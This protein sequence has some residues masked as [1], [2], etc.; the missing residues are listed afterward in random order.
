MFL[1]EG[2]GENGEHSISFELICSKS[3]RSLLILV[4]VKSLCSSDVQYDRL[5]NSCIA[6]LNCADIGVGMVQRALCSSDSPLPRVRPPQV[7]NDFISVCSITRSELR[8]AQNWLLR[9]IT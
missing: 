4:C 6:A 3:T 2:T 5:V 1:N 7:F 8:P 9:R